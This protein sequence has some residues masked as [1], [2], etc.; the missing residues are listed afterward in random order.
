M[1]VDLLVEMFR[2]IPTFRQVKDEAG[3]PLTRVKEI[4]A[5]TDG[6]L[7]VFSGF[8]VATMM[9]EMESGFSG[10][11][12]FVSLADVYAAAFDLFHKDQ[13]REAFDMFGRWR[14]AP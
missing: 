8:G 6:Q 4:H 1:S 7:K 5:R 9:T 12:P 3:N 14:P 11:C 13:R 10:H 2:T